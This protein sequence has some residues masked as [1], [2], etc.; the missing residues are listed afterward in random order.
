MR[1]RCVFFSAMRD[2]RGS[3]LGLGLVGISWVMD[4]DGWGYW[5]YMGAR[6]KEGGGLVIYG[7]WATVLEISYRCTY[8][9]TS[10]KLCITLP[11]PSHARK[12]TRHFRTDSGGGRG[13]DRQGT[14]DR[15]TDRQGRQGVCV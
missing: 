13:T 6:L 4:G 8:R 7:L 5:G 2:A 1:V 9:Q 15:P 14:T 10:V 3:G 11:S 12:R